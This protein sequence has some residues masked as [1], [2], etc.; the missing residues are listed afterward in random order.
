MKKKKKKKKKSN[1]IKKK[2]KNLPVTGV[3][4]GTSSR[5]AGALGGEPPVLVS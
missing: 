3:C 2:K 1:L 4:A 5:G